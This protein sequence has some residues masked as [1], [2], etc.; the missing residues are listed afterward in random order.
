MFISEVIVG[1]WF[2]PVVLFIAIPLS[3]LCVWSVHRLMR[4]TTERIEQAHLNAKAAQN[5]SPV[6]SL[7]PRLAV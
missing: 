2:V 1:L 3:V 4:K 7:R 5:E 6:Q